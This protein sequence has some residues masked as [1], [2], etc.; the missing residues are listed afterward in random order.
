M[1]AAMHTT[2]SRPT[3]TIP[4]GSGASANRAP[5]ISTFD[6]DYDAAYGAVAQA[7]SVEDALAMMQTPPSGGS[8]TKQIMKEMAIDPALA[9]ANIALQRRAETHEAGIAVVFPVLNAL[10]YHDEDLRPHLPKAQ[11]LFAKGVAES[12]KVLDELS[13]RPVG[14]ESG[15]S[16]QTR[17]S[18]CPDVMRDARAL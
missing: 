3:N 8:V 10:G 4:P 17:E 2:L 1:E 13:G 7:D 18:A 14:P 12:Q 6:P 15:A 11:R 9:M 5:L 16:Q